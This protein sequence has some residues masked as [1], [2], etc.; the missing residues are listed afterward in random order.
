MN[1][2]KAGR[3]FPVLLS[4]STVRDDTGQAVGL[5]GVATDITERRQVEEALRHEKT[6]LD[7]L[8]NNIPDSIYFKD[9]QC[10]LV[11]INRK[12]MQNLKLDDMSQ[13]IGKTD[14]ELFGEEFGR[15]NQSWA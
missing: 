5:V 10:R 11:R 14:V 9:R 4:T 3:E 2:T 7:A 15:T 8:M 6:L 1:R 13:A 12:M